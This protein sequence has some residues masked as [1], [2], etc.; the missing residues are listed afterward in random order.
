MALLLHALHCA[1]NRLPAGQSNYDWGVGLKPLLMAV[2]Y[3]RKQSL[4][5]RCRLAV[6]GSV[7]SI[8]VSFRLILQWLQ[9]KKRKICHSEAVINH[10][11]Q[12]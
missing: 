6:A 11:M 4:Q 5:W 12:W 3:S 7:S 1:L 9:K 10:V 2:K 8:V